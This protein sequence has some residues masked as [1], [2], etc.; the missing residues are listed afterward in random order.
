MILTIRTYVNYV[1]IETAID[2]ATLEKQIKTD[3][4]AFTQNFLIPYEKSEYASYFLQHENNM[5]LRNE[6]IIKFEEMNKKQ[7][8][9]DST[10]T[11][12]EEIQKNPNTPQASWKKYIIEKLKD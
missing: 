12:A 7:E 1:S 10:A 6:F 4:L 8:A 9:L 3:E 5:L 2:S 11:Y